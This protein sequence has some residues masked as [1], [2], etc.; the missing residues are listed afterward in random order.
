MK[1]FAFIFV[2]LLLFS[3]SS[4]DTTTFGLEKVDTKMSQSYG[5]VQAKADFV[6]IKDGNLW[7]NV[8]LHNLSHSPAQITEKDFTLETS[9]PAISLSDK[10]PYQDHFL[11]AK[12]K[13][14]MK[15]AFPLNLDDKIDSV[16]FRYS[17]SHSEMQEFFNV[18]K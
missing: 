8:T 2:A 5:P 7:F 12:T 15:V 16:I 9:G 4:S 1:I 18:T 6:E 13:T 11:P 10:T 3:C 14:I 17:S